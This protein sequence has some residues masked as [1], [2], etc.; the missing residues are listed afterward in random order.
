MWPVGG[1]KD[2]NDDD[3]DDVDDDDDTMTLCLADEKFVIYP[4]VARRLL[5]IPN[6]NKIRRSAPHDDDGGLLAQFPKQLAQPGTAW[7]NLA[8]SGIFWHN[9]V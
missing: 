4:A 2:D 1:G 3:E 7:Y 8:L 6:F 5:P 9:M